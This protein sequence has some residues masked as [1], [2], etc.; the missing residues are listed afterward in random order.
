MKNKEVLVNLKMKREE[1]KYSFL[2]MSRMLGVSKTYY[3]QIEN[4]QRRLTYDMA[5]KISKILKT[6]P[7]NLFYNEF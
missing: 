5:K 6:K 3:W 1:M 2:D 4:R 7:D